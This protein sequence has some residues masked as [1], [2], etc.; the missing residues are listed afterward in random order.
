M[1]KQSTNKTNRNGLKV[2][3]SQSMEYLYNKT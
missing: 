1:T 3:R 2:K